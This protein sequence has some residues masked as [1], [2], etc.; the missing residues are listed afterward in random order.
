MRP[1]GPIKVAVKG[2]K[3]FAATQQ[4]APSENPNALK[5]RKQPQDGLS[6]HRDRNGRREAAEAGGSDRAVEG[7]E[8]QA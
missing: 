4:T 2:F 3:A 1:P 8:R 6:E 7:P 5:D